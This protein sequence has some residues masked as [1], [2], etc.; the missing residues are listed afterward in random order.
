MKLPSV[1]A[2]LKLR[3]RA[4]KPREQTLVL[5]A[6]AL[7][8]AALLWWVG[9][10]PALTTL[11][12]A[13]AQQAALATDMEK[14]QRLRAQALAIQSQPKMDRAESIRALESLVKQ[15]LGSSAQM[16]VVGDRVTV[17]LKGTGPD[18]LS[19]W[20]SQARINARAVPSEVRLVRVAGS[21]NGRATWEGSVAFSMAAP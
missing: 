17:T 13:R 2:P 16:N 18:E 14:M 3:W 9:L 11:Q 20:L 5:G 19:Q 6:L 1:L 15:R 12:V 21:A 10:S 7:V 8:C 4:L